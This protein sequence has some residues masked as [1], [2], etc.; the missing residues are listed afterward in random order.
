MGVA[1]HRCHETRVSV[2]LLLLTSQFLGYPPSMD[3]KA[4]VTESEHSLSCPLTRSAHAHAALFW[5]LC[6]TLDAGLGCI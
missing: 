4:E 5:W 6:M 1:P 2:L 3:R